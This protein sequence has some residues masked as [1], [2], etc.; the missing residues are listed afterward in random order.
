MTRFSIKYR[1]P[2]VGPPLVRLN[3]AGP[4]RNRDSLDSRPDPELRSDLFQI[5]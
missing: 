2:R 1:A 5:S 3:Q 4:D